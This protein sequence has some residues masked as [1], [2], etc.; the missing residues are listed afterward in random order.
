MNNQRRSCVLHV[1]SLGADGHG[2][3]AVEGNG[4]AGGGHDR[5]LVRE[6]REVGSLGDRAQVIRESSIALLRRSQLHGLARDRRV[7][8]ASVR[9]GRHLGLEG[10]LDLEEARVL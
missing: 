1:P 10:G 9:L 7:K 8:V 2:V 3:P 5:P 4:R 6:L